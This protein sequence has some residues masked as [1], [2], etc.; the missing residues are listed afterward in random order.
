MF[1]STLSPRGALI[2]G[3][4]DLSRVKLY[5]R[6]T[7]FP[8]GVGFKLC[9]DKDEEVHLG[10]TAMLS[11]TYSALRLSPVIMDDKRDPLGL[12]VNQVVTREGY[13]CPRMNGRG[14]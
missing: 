7:S 10:R 12:T 14:G 13:M 2:I 1:K 5:R 11:L 4:L 8:R 9:E 3:R 6:A